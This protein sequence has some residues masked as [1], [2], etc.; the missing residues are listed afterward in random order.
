MAFNNSDQPLTL[1]LPLARANLGAAKSLTDRL[2][3]LGTIV[4]GE[5]ERWTPK[6][7]PVVKLDFSRTA[8][9]EKEQIHETKTQTV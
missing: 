8:Q 2:G 4:V 5:G 6:L 3:K 7:R 1:E 9:C